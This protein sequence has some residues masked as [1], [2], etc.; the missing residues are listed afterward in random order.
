M[1]AF[2]GLLL[3]G[4]FPDIGLSWLA[5]IGLVPLLFAVRNLPWF[6]GF[7]LGFLTGMVHYLTLI[8]WIA[9]TMRTYG[10]LPWPVGLS[11]LTLLA[12]C[13]AAFTGAFA[14]LICR[15][16]PPP[17][18]ALFFAPISWVALEYLRSFFLSGFPWELLGYSQY[19]QLHLIQISDIVGV[20]GVSFL[21]LFSSTAVFLLLLNLT[22]VDWY[23]ARVSQQITAAAVVLS[24]G[25]SGAN[26]FYGEHRLRTVDKI[27]GSAPSVRAAFVQGNIEQALKWD[28]AFQEATIDKYLK[29]SQSIAHRNPQLVVWPETA[30]PFHYK[31]DASMTEKVRQGVRRLGTHFLV[32]SPS[33]TRQPHRVDYFNSAYLIAPQGITLGRYDKAHLVPFGEYVPLKRWLP[34]LGKLVAQVGDFSRGKVGKTIG[35]V[36]GKV[37]V[38]ICYEGIFPR[39]ARAMARNGA[40]LLV[41]IT[42]DAWYG[43]SSAPYQHFSMT[44]LRAVEN[45]RS[46]IRAA[47]T[48]ISGFVDPAGRIA[49]KTAIF[50]D[51]ADVRQVPLLSTIS[52]YSRIGDVFAVVCLVLTGILLCGALTSKWRGATKRSSRR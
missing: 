39:L 38:L 7:G 6:R 43:R 35:W 16:Q 12:A 33:F 44:V 48:G 30:L 5:W 37:G 17:L 9:Y 13:L 15:L 19:K 3:T 25:L 32:G 23:G 24:L 45:R 10:H 50:S 52:L 29:L 41:N 51:A 47:N 4:A 46:L 22:K 1:A 27:S 21:I 28:P 20:Y 42:N 36:H 40:N 26:W 34:F 18:A 31:F 49:G 14:A 8:Y 11:I 2:S